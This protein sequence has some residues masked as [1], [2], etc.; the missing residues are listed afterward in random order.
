MIET[1]IAALGERL[2]VR[3]LM[4]LY[5]HDFSEIDGLIW[6]STVS[7]ATTISTAFGSI[8]TG[9]HTSLLLKVSGQAL[10]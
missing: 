6:M 5:Q 10:P 9:R 7:M 2:V 4:E 3:N 8:P 1:R